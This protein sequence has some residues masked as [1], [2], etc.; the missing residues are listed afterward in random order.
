[1]ELLRVNLKYAG[2]LNK[3]STIQDIHFI[4]NNS[5]LVGLIG[6]NGAGKS[7]TIKAIVGLLPEVNGE[8]CF[9]CE[10]KTYAYIPE[11]PILYDELTL[12]EH[13]ELV[14]S[15]YEM[16]RSYFV[17][18]VEELLNQF[19][20]TEV[21]HNFPITFSKGMQQ[22]L[23]IIIG[24]LI[25]PAIYIIDEPF[26]GL[27]PRATMQFTHLL[28]K[29]KVRGASMLISTHQLD[30]AEKICDSIIL[31]DNGR[32]ITQGNLEQIR[33]KCHL[34]NA[35]LFDCFNYLLEKEV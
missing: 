7:T 1:M 25:Q 26:V 20:L 11:Q 24:L 3:K 33:E 28:E 4:I 17:K 12:W 13:L 15:A 31:F 32:L 8:I 21:K 19:Q 5:E 14:A 29:E 23:M 34:P 30:I 35:S 10:N 6:P 22:K 16:N 9:M 2:Y 18:K 27:D